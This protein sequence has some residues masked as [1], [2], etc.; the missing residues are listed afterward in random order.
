MAEDGEEKRRD[1]VARVIVDSALTVHKALGPGLLEGVYEECLAYELQS[2]GHAAQRQVAC[3]VTYRDIRLEPAFRMDMVV[4]GVVVVEVKSVETLLPV[5]E[6]QLLTYLRFSGLGLGLL[7]NFN[8]R[9]IKDGLRRI[10][11]G[12]AW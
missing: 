11:L 4:D 5:H 7:A 3:P 1:A 8:V 12:F 6:E 9:L 2:R 10:R